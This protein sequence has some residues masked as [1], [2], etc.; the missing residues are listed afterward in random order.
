MKKLLILLP[1]LMLLLPQSA[2]AGRRAGDLDPSFGRAG[3]VVVPTSVGFD[4]PETPPTAIAKLPGNRTVV[5]AGTHLLAFDANGDPD[6]GFG[7]G[8]VEVP[9]PAG[10]SLQLVD[11]AADVQGGI[12]VAGTVL[13]PVEPALRW[14]V[15]H[16]EDTFL[17]RFTPNGQLDPGFGQGGVLRSD[18]GFPS[19]PPIPTLPEPIAKAPPQTRIEG[20]A[21][22]PAGRV[23]ISAVRVRQ[24]S[25]CRFY[26]YH[27][28]RD[29]FLA[30]LNAGGNLD[31]AYGKGGIV[32]VEG[33]TGA[34]APVL[35]RTGGTYL[36]DGVGS[37]CNLVPSRLTRFDINGAVAQPAVVTDIE[38]TWTS[39]AID[40]R[41]RVLVVESLYTY[42][43]AAV[44][45]ILPGG[46]MDAKF[47]HNGVAY[48]SS[49]TGLDFEPNAVKAG[50]KGEVVLVGA[51]RPFGAA[52]DP[53][54]FMVA[55]LTDS[56]KLDR[57][58]SDDGVVQTR[59]GRDSRA[60]AEDVALVRGGILVSGRISLPA[61]Q[62]GEGLALA[63]YLV[64]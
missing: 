11:V 31:A 9:A 61:L 20:I 59:F 39:L 30:R 52:V 5:L 24:I 35:T 51:A 40:R 12:F 7:G 50:A 37:G 27:P 46:R 33:S 41:G 16:D 53:R 15:G 25:S 47:G 6:V 42:G 17:A 34:S 56:G 32:L 14:A 43:R 36:L 49:P 58:F 3:R 57:S 21:I 48:V 38:T 60:M 55:R 29:F 18:F 23:V 22:D 26:P 54:R 44:R 4:A 19:P 64:R 10:T 63:R 28:H 2:A 1:V 62:G 8:K 13:S 45:R